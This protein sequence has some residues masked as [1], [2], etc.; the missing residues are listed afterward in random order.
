M[1]WLVS[2][3]KLENGVALLILHAYRISSPNRPCASG[4]RHYF[5]LQDMCPRNLILKEVCTRGS[6][7]HQDSDVHIFPD[8]SAEALLIRCSLKPLTTAL[9]EVGIRYQWLTLGHLQAIHKG[10][11]LQVLDMDEGNLILCTLRLTSPMELDEKLQ[12]K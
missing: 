7:K 6:F 3:L 4:S 9:M 10:F 11:V 1:R 2:Q 5:G 12:K 8:V